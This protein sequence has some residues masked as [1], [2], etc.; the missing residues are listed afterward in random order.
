[1]YLRYYLDDA[2]KRVYTL[3][4]KLDDGTYTQNAHPGTNFS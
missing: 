3:K 2:G 4:T 1:M